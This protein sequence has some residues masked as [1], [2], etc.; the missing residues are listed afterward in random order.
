MRRSG[1]KP[2][3]IDTETQRK[4]RDTEKDSVLKKNAFLRVSSYSLC[5]CDSVLGLS[6]LG[7]FLLLPYRRRRAKGMVL[8]RPPSTGNAWPFTYEASSLARNSAIAAISSG[9]P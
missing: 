1:V 2:K 7:L 6:V 8:V 4:S 3:D 9:R 5:L